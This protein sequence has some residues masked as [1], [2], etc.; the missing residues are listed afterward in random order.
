MRLFN[1]IHTFNYDYWHHWILQ[2]IAEMIQSVKSQNN[3]KTWANIL[4]QDPNEAFYP[5]VR[6]NGQ[7]WKYTLI[8]MNN[9]K[10]IDKDDKFQKDKS[11]QRK[12]LYYP[13]RLH[14]LVMLV[15]KGFGRSIIGYD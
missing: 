13:K 4:K 10:V 15:I 12:N 7:K 1:S 11:S 5:N 9:T 2:D 6:F 14:T 8:S 3:L